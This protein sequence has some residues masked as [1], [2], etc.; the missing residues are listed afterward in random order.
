MQ[1]NYSLTS[2][3]APGRA[4]GQI[5]AARCHCSKQ[6]IKYHSLTQNSSTSFSIFRTLCWNESLSHRSEPSHCFFGRPFCLDPFSAFVSQ[7]AH[8]LFEARNFVAGLLSSQWPAQKKKR[9][10]TA[11]REVYKSEN[12]QNI[13]HRAEGSTAPG[14]ELWHCTG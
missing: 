6:E 7:I 4:T 9:L 1:I 11:V 13:Q 14:A 3:S 5:S 10:A 8:K 2:S 12:Y